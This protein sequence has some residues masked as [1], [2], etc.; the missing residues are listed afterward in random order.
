MAEDMVVECVYVGTG[1]AF[2]LKI[3][4]KDFF[5]EKICMHDI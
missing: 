1:K 3:E 2:N 5:I 4:N